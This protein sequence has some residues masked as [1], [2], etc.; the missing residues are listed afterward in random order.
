VNQDDTAA[1][2]SA[3]C[4]IAEDAEWREQVSHEATRLHE[5]LFNPDRLQAIF[6]GEIEKL[7]AASKK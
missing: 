6:V 5:T 2:V 4:R 7:V 1:I 3:C